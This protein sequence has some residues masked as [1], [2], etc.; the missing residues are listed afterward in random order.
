MLP[1]TR[2][3]IALDRRAFVKS[4]L[5]PAL[6]VSA[7]WPEWST[8]DE[9]DRPAPEIV[10][11]NVHLFQWPFRPL[12]YAR[13]DALVKKL[14]RHR[15]VQAWAGTFE[16]VLHKQLDRANRRLAE[17]CQSQEMLVPVGSVN[18]V[19]P[20]WEEDL[21][22]CHEKYKMP[23]IRLYPAYHGYALDDSRLPKLLEAAGKRGLLVQIVLRMEDERIHHP[24]ITAPLVDA[25]P[26]ASLLPKLPQARVQLLNC[27]TALRG[28]EFPVL[29]RHVTFDIAGIE[30]QGMV[31]KLLTGQAGNSVDLPAERLLFGTHAPYFPCESA[32]F[33]LFES[34]LS[35]EQLQAVMHQNA[36]RLLA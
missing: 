36:R 24:T 30:G 4:S 17:E 2:R 19:W 6:A 10:D 11:T 7:T 33:K 31:G 8:A 28:Q 27:G 23:A 14:R 18:P 3:A 9:P 15:I 34:P 32:L 12:K 35:L 26:L 1:S 21:R 20:E 29:A 25:G 16:A 22:R 13:T 5:L